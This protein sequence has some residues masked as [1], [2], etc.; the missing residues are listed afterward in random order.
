MKY[1]PKRLLQITLLTGLTLILYLLVFSGLLSLFDAG[2]SKAPQPQG[3][4]FGDDPPLSGASTCGSNQKAD[5]ICYQLSYP[6]E[7]S[8]VGPIAR[9]VITDPVSVGADFGSCT[10]WRIGPNNHMLANKHCIADQAQ[11]AA[12]EFW[13]NYQRPKCGSGAPGPVVKVAGDTLLAVDETLDFALFTVKDFETIAGFGYLNLDIRPPI[14]GEEIYIPQ[15]GGGKPK[16]FGIENDQSDDNL[17]HIDIASYPSPIDDTPD[18]DT[19]Y[20][21]DTI[22]GSSGS[23]VLA[24]SSHRVVALHHW[25]TC[26]NK[27]VRID[28]L[29]PV[30]KSKVCATEIPPELIYPDD[31]NTSNVSPTFMWSS[32]ADVAEYNLQVDNQANFTSPVISMTITNTLFNPVS[33]LSDSLYF[34]RVRGRSIFDSC[35]N[36]SGWSETRS[37]IITTPQKTDPPETEYIIYLPLIHK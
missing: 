28:K 19:A 7:Y 20:T 35:D 25:G 23:P 3:L 5:V 15:H 9:M 37:M 27:A 24:R 4:T 2:N 26:P 18:T 31:G 34:W 11:L 13:F 8:R 16:E 10:A 12:A 32:L 29:W 36:Y 6:R 17:C 30:I 21:C 33:A 22:T 1:R 14:A